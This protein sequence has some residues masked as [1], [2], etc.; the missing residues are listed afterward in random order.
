MT[1]G[2]ICVFAKPPRPG[3]AKTRLAPMLG[4]GGAA[5]LA[6]AF[7][8]D[9][10]A[11]LRA[12]RDA[13]VVL[14][15]TG[16]FDAALDAQLGLP[17]WPQGEGDLGARLE[18]V[19]Q[20][21]LTGAP[22][23]IALGGDSP[24]RPPGLT[25]DAIAALA[26]PEVDAVLGPSDDG[27]FYLLGLRRCPP[28]LLA[29]LPW[30]SATTGAATLARLAS[31]GLR[32]RVLGPWFDVDEP[33][34]LQR[35]D[36]LIAQGA[37]AAPATAEVRR[38]PRVSVVMPV[39]D[40]ARRLGAALDHLLELPGVAEL[41]VVDGGSQDASVAIATRPGVTV[42]A[43]PRGRASQQNA[44]A[45]GATGDVLLFV[46]ADTTLPRDAIAHVR[47]TLAD[48]A[49]CAG[50]FWTRHVVDADAAGG[51]RAAPPWYA[52]AMRLA[53]LRSRYTG[54]PYGDQAIFVRTSAFQA[55]GGFPAQALME[56]LELSRR[57]RRHG[58]IATVHANVDVSARR[59]V[60]S[61]VRMTLAVNV[62]PLLYRLGVSPETL[63]SYYRVIR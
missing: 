26:D 19:L 49:V 16:P 59:F 31:A 62:M 14:A 4:A 38:A 54:L 46:H 56:D 15:T 20:R 36:E 63:A 1:A 2:V 41:I 29:E 18:R 37:I 50:A 42:R 10:C 17:C 5:E 61:P 6:R 12:R 27:G 35:L 57:L 32:T 30:S 44:G 58:R 40:E 53:D 33:A 23:A 22:W 43:A 21:A 3:L 45:A 11:P 8:L 28:G 24:G 39:L 25:D 13:R 55:V 60:A 7:L 48:P 34:D 47:R 51:A 52:P 9:T